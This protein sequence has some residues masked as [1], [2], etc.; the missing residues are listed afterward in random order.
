MIFDDESVDNQP[1]HFSLFF[2][3]CLQTFCLQP[4][5][6]LHIQ[7]V[8]EPTERGLESKMSKKQG[9]KKGGAKAAGNAQG[10]NFF[11]RK[12]WRFKIMRNRWWFI[13]EGSIFTYLPFWDLQMIEKRH[14]WK[15]ITDED[16][17]AILA[18]LDVADKEKAAKDGKKGKGG[19][20]GQ[21]I[22]L[23]LGHYKTQTCNLSVSNDKTYYLRLSMKR[24][25]T[26]K[27]H[28]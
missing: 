15:W 5:I 26:R 22:R 17:D 21:N 16:L 10:G 11:K 27:V 18:E 7:A 23:V 12:I 3:V 2:F 28:R 9:G 19:K 25:L 13:V 1:F 24:S 14:D 4:S 8:S 20:K 6:D